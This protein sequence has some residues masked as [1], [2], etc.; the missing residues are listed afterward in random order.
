MDAELEVKVKTTD[1]NLFL[2]GFQKVANRIAS[3]LVLAALIIGAAL[4]M[5][6]DRPFAF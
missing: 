4:L 5:Q 3:A 2:Q 6:V 1:A